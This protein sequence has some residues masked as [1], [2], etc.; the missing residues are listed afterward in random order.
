MPGPPTV[1]S[2]HS[3][4][5]QYLGNFL[6]HMSNYIPA[7]VCVWKDPTDGFN[8]FSSGFP[9][10]AFTANDSFFCTL[11]TL[12]QCSHIHLGLTDYMGF[13]SASCRVQTLPRKAFDEKT[14][15]Q[16][17]LTSAANKIYIISY[18]S[19]RKPI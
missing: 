4:A 5:Q 9:A 19:S 17:V 10:T 2:N 3:I 18:L 14:C 15:G 7:N 11:S 6:G 13:S 12:Q 8:Q 16:I 1:P